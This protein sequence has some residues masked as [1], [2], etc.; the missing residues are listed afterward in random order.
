MDLEV[1][2]LTCPSCSHARSSEH[3]YGYLE[4]LLEE[5]RLRSRKD[6]YSSSFEMKNLFSSIVILI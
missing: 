3:R 4:Q 5:G 6:K 1:V 2:I